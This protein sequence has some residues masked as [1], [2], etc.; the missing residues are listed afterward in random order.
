[1]WA[2]TMDGTSCW[3]GHPRYSSFFPSLS[4]I[5]SL[6]LSLFNSIFNFLFPFSPH[7]LLIF[8]QYFSDHFG[9]IL[10]KQPYLSGLPY[11]V[12]VAFL[13]ISGYLSDWMITKVRRI[14]KREGMGREAVIHTW[15]HCG[16]VFR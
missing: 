12:G 8:F 6:S 10:H 4:L 5:P 15:T 7:L 14:A 13:H 16:D 3:D 11:I 1:M 9:V 2:I